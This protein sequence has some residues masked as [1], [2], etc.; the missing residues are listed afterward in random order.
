MPDRPSL[1]SQIDAPLV[2]RRGPTWPAI[3]FHGDDALIEKHYI[4]KRS[5]RQKGILAFLVQDAATR[6]FCY[7]SGEL[8]KSDQ[9]DEI[10]HFARFWKKRTGHY[11]EELIF[12]PS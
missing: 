9:N 10:L 6:V 3:P 4:S 2:R 8:R 7:A 1:L 11:P 12:I 5:R